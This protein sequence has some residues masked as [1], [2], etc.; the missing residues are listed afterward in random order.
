MANTRISRG[1][2]NK[3]ESPS[4]LRDVIELLLLWNLLVQLLAKKFH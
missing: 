2:G 4:H 1:T 3:G